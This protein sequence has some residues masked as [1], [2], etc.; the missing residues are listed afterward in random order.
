M[1]LRDKDPKAATPRGR[2]RRAWQAYDDRRADV[3]DRRVFDLGPADR[4]QN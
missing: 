3:L 2:W 1:S 4:G